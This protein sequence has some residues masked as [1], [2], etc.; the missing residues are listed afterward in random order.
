MEPRLV[1]MT[2]PSEDEAVSLA[3]MLVAERLAACV[4]ILGEIRSFFRWEGEVC[5]EGEIAFIAKTTS[6]R[7]NQLIVRVTAAHS[8]D[9]PC[10]VAL[11]ITG[12]HDEFLTWIGTETATV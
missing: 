4:N 3:R 5:D 1:Y 12:G 7:L 9:C 6:D 10:V 8:Y 11:P 2:A